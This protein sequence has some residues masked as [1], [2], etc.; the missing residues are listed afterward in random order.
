[1]V[2]EPADDGDGTVLRFR[3]SPPAAKFAAARTPEAQH[4]MLLLPRWLASDA[5]K[6]EPKFAAITPSDALDEQERRTPLPFAPT[7]TDKRAQALAR[8]RIVHR[9][10]Q[11]LP[12]VVPARRGEAMQRYLAR[13]KGL[14]AA[15]RA[16]L[17]A[18]VMAILDDPRFAPLFAG[19]RAEVPIVGRIARPGLPPLAVSGQIDRLAVTPEAVLIA[20]YKTNRPA[21]R[22]IE[23]VPVGYVAQLALYRAVL[24]ALYPD[25]QVRAALLWTD[26]PELM[27]VPA[28]ALD[29][30]LARVTSP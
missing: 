9:L 29:Q 19:S 7:G 8:G 17:A 13:A 27:E 21:P 26:V 15:E 24:G 30:A 14:D 5:P 22:R 2:E 25:R 18:Q 10:M 4:S 11:S 12:D 1:M 20:D 6:D 16:A 23:D 28:A 3:K